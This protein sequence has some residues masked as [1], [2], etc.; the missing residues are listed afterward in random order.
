MITKDQIEALR[1]LLNTRPMFGTFALGDGSKRYFCASCGRR[2]EPHTDL[3]ISAPIPHTPE[4]AEQAHWR[5]IETLKM[6][7]QDIG[8]D[9]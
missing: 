6:I 9:G 5:A 1:P 3:P 8:V 7:L 2:S 4:C